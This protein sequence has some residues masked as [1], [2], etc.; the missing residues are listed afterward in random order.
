MRKNHVQ[1]II[2]A[3]LSGE[4]IRCL[5]NKV[6]GFYFEIIER[7]LNQSRFSSR[8]KIAIIDQ[9]LASLKAHEGNNASK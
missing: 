3:P 1:R 6:N 4:A 2:G 5:I 9:I 7:K 8:Q